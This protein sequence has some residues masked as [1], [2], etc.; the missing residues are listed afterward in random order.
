MKTNLCLSLSCLIA[1]TAVAEPRTWTFCTGG[2]IK[3]PSGG[4]S[5]AKGGRIDAEFLRTDGTNVFFFMDGSEGSV[6]LASLSD[7][8]RDYVAKVKN[9]PVDQAR[10]APEAHK[11]EIHAKQFATP[12]DITAYMKEH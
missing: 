10:L 7:A 6:P 5:F 2:K 9:A 4:M 12:L 1:F 11:R 8:D 3:F